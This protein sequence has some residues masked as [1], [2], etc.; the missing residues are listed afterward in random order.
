MTRIAFTL[1][2]LLS[3]SAAFAGLSTSPIWMHV[4]DLGDERLSV[5]FV[6]Y[7]AAGVAVEVEQAQLVNLPNGGQRFASGG[8]DHPAGNNPDNLICA[9]VDAVVGAKLRMPT[10]SGTSP[11]GTP[12]SYRPNLLSETCVAIGDVAGA[13]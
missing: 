11:G 10:W 6:L 1:A 2:A 7:N 4:T 12:V 13:Q 9:E 3:S 5:H 8:F